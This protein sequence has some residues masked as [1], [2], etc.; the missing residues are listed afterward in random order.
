MIGHRSALL[1]HELPD[2][3]PN[4]ASHI[5]KVGG[6]ALVDYARHGVTVVLCVR[7]VG[8]LVP[9]AIGFGRQGV[10]NVNSFYEL[11]CHFPSP[12]LIPGEASGRGNLWIQHEDV[13][14]ESVQF[15][16]EQATEYKRSTRD[17]YIQRLR[18]RA[19]VSSAP[20]GIRAA[21]TLFG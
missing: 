3:E 20:D 6:Q 5:V 18:T 14:P 10:Q 2:G 4:A 11:A 16:I 12:P 19:L 15:R 13:N 7:P 17:A 8:N 1:I 9:H 21:D